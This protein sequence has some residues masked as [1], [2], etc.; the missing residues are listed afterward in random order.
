ML[1]SLPILALLGCALAVTRPA[2]AASDATVNMGGATIDIT[3]ATPA[4]GARRQLLLDWVTASARAVSL[5]YG[6]YP[7]PRVELRI[8]AFPGRGVH[9][10]RASGW[11][12]P[13]IVIGAGAD[14]T[15]RDFATDWMLT[16]EMIHLAF[17]SVAERHHWI[18]E[19]ISVYVE[20]IARARAG[21]ISAEDAWKDLVEGVPQGLPAADD[22]GLDFTPT[23][24]RTYWGGALFCLLADVEIHKRT[25]GAKGLEDALRAI[26]RAGGTITN[27]WPLQRAFEIGDR[28]T[29]V[30][31]LREL[32]DKM[33][34]RPYTPDLAALWTELG[35][36]RR[37]GR[38]VFNDRA[39]LASVR[40]AIDPGKKSAAPP[41]ALS[42]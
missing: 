2:R 8:S 1:R 33:S 23:W 22:R 35:I 16:H 30:T 42:N 40:E 34:A 5:Y 4:D 9:G 3:F 6:Q 19:G 29:G 17:P 24:G 37:G 41:A 39:P 27:D 31:V 26:Q 12:G 14:N 10:G 7:V 13:R 11:R 38:V 15:A 32:Y 18:E 28:A 36:E 25:K 21:L 20:P